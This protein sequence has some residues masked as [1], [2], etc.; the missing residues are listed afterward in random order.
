M[1]PFRP[2]FPLLCVALVAGAATFARQHHRAALPVVAATQPANTRE[3]WAVDLLGRLGNMQPTGATV[4]FLQAW[5]RAEGG[6]A[7][8]NWLNTTQPAP[9]ATD[10]NA[11]GVKNYPDYETGIAAT[12]ETLI[13]DHPGYA[14]IVAGLQSNNIDL[15]MAG[16]RASPWGTHAGLVA[17]V[18]AEIAP[19]VPENG[20]QRATGHKSNVTP[21]MEIGARFDTADCAT[22]GF[23]A[24]CRHWGTD[25]LGAEGTPVFAP[26]DL[27]I[28]ALG[29]Y[30][31]GP[32]WGQYVQGTLADGYVFYAGHLE[33]R[34]AMRGG[35]TLPAGAVLGF[36]NGLAHT[37]IQL[38]PPGNTG[39]CAQDG[40]C[41]DFERYFDEH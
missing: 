11:V 3:A 17:D 24:G 2:L 16:L 20:A 9:G 14:E 32:T 31:P 40:S 12:V 37:H 4:A 1:T 30:G 38:A 34:A 28:I 23:Q 29:E 22:W 5:H 41:V 33:G 15:V 7:A 35:D 10:Y 26:F 25:F 13:S 27:T 36:T 8:F 21:T 18:Y 19:V 39:A 6:T